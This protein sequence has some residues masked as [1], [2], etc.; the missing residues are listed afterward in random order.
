MAKILKFN[1]SWFSKEEKIEHEDFRGPKV[2]S[3]SVPPERNVG[4]SLTPEE[5]SSFP[6]EVASDKKIDT[7]FMQ[8]ISDRLYG[9]DSKEYVEALRELNKKF[10]AREGRYGPQFYDDQS[11]SEVKIRQSEINRTIK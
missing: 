5:I 3:T 9:P 11:S 6:K 10:K 2:Q 7:Y 1:E 8:E 4:K